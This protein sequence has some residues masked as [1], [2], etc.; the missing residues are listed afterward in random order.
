MWW[1]EL[2]RRPGRIYLLLF[3]FLG[4]SIM[5][6]LQPRTLS[7]NMKSNVAFLS[8]IIGISTLYSS[9]NVFSNILKPS[10]SFAEELSSLNDSDKNLLENEKYKKNIFNVPP[11][12][13]QYPLYFEGTWL[14]DYDFQS[15]I[16]TPTI[17]FQQLS[18]DVNVAGFRKY[19]ILKF[20]DV[21][22]NYKNI[23]ATYSRDITSGKSDHV[24]EN[25]ISNVNN[26]FLVAAIKNQ[27]IID[28][29]EY[30]GQQNPNRLSLSF[31][32]SSSYGRIE[33]FTNSRSSSSVNDQNSITMNDQL[34]SIN[35]FQTIEF[36]RQSTSRQRFGERPSQ[37][38]CDYAIEYTYEPHFNTQTS[39]NNNS[40]N[41]K[42]KST[43][44]VTKKLDVTI[45]TA[46]LITNTNIKDMTG[47]CRIFS[48]IIPQD[49]LYFQ[50]PSLPV[51]LFSY[52]FKMTKQ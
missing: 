7:T 28:N 2:F 24:N 19:S 52:N 15:A 48:Y 25:V 26:Q 47:K 32:D 29:I 33:T 3:G 10:N 40:D 16:F 43:S 39:S 36:L 45:N 22:S 38:I 5:K 23:I 35:S 18:S 49:D 34:P 14:C 9:E 31:H 50:R 11:Q 41:L 30:D 20:P 46:E 27:P 17:P 8:K 37:L 6:N 12:A 42:P 51:C 21:G 4:K 13:F 1:N 44:E